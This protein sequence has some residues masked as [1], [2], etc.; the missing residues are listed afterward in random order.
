MDKNLVKQKLDAI[1]QYTQLMQQFKTMTFN[2]YINDLDRQLTAE[3]LLQ[4]LI[5]TS[6]KVNAYLVKELH[7]IQ[8]QDSLDA[9]KLAGEYGIL[10]QPLTDKFLEFLPI[11]YHLLFE[12]DQIN[13]KRVYQ[14][15]FMA[16]DLYPLYI[17]ELTNYLDLMETDN[18]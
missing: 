8:A 3:R 1:K 10:S 11:E 7:D 6:S 16:L 12:Y 2:G 9:F 5:A 14:A 15:I 18:G 13:Y 4:L 17:R